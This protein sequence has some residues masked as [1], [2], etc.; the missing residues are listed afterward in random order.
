MA[1]AHFVQIDRDFVALVDA[2]FADAARR[3][4]SHLLCRP[5]CSQCCIGVFAIGPADALR[6]ERGSVELE[7]TDPERAARVRKR[8]ESSWQRLAAHF[9]G[10]RTSGV[11]QTAPDGEPAEAFDDF[12]DA[13]PCPALDPEQGRC[14][15]YAAR[16]Y[17]C[18]VFGP[19][20]ETSEGFGVCELCF[21][22]A[23]PAEI[24]SAAIAAPE[25]EQE[26]VDRAAVAARTAA[27]HTIVAAVLG[28]KRG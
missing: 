17:T 13:E 5:G 8:A 23:S 2:A 3:S 21:Q 7:A 10:D 24:A 9:P 15:L 25:L 18:R 26:A 6:L 16:P 27:G 20:V 11:L 1:G 19:P 22:E 14:D 12:A 28:R 4:G